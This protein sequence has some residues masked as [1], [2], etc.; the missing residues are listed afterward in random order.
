MSLTRDEQRVVRRI[1]GWK[2]AD[3]LASPDAWST[4]YFGQSHFDALRDDEHDWLECDGTKIQ[5]GPLGDYYF[6]LKWARVKKYARTLPAS[7]RE[8]LAKNRRARQLNMAAYPRFAASAAACGHGRP[9]T[10]LDQEGPIT[11]GQAL[12]EAEYDAWVASGVMERWEAERDVLAAEQDRLLDEALPLAVSDQPA[13]F[14][15]LV[16]AS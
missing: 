3:L 7:L 6:S 5:V 14:L 11:E 4:D 16:G 2:I 13:D 9:V 10:W 1:G 15:E 8:D 12:Y